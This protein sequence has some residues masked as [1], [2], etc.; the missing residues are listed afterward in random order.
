MAIVS[1][2]GTAEPF[3][4]DGE[5]YAVFGSRVPALRSFRLTYPAGRDRELVLIQVLAG[6]RAEDLSPNAQNQPS[7]IPDG[8]LQVRLQDADPS[9]EEF[10][11]NIS[12]SLLR[13][14][15]A[16]RFQIR[17][18]GCVGACQRELPPE[19][20]DS[21]DNGDALR[22]PLIAL[23]GFRV[24]FIGNREQELD[25]VGVWFTGNELNVALRDGNSGDTFGYLVDFVVIPTV[26]LNV[27]TG[28][29]R[30][31]ADGL[32]RVPFPTPSRAHFML[33]GWAF[34]FQPGDRQIL[35]IGVL[36]DDDS[37]TVFYADNGGGERFDWRI[38]WAHVAPI[39]VAPTS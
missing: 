25:R 22:R 17:D 33:T 10:G 32:Q 37:F 8:R 1:A 6:G 7:S 26:G 2:Q 30:G 23:V 5:P 14:P 39:V 18:V 29:E 36:R 34:N 19:V 28:I 9:G 3:D 27:T 24:F 13:I 31:T 20:M 16:R 4:A 21:A 11:Y 35:D 15:G 12:H 38:E